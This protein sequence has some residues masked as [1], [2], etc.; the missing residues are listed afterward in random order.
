M[1]IRNK[2]ILA[3]TVLMAVIL[4]IGILSISSLK[5]V[6]NYSTVIDETVIPRL[7]CVENLNFEVARYRSYEYQHI[8]LS[9]AQS[10]SDVETKMNDLQSSIEKGIKEYQA[11]DNS[12]SISKIN[13][14]WQT[15]MTEHT[16][17]IEASRKLDTDLSMTV[18]K[19][20]SKTSYDSIAAELITLIAQNKEYSHTQSTN[21]NQAYTNIQN[22][23]LIVIILAMIA[24]VLIEIF[25][26]NSVKKPLNLMEVKLRELV[27]QGGDLTKKIEINSKDEIGRLA[28]EV[29]KF[30][31]N[32]RE[33]ILE[34]NT[35]T[36][37]VERTVNV[38]IDNMKE[39]GKSM[40]ESSATVQELSAGMEETA[41]SAEEINSSATEIDNAA[42]AMADR[43]QQG[44]MS[45]AEISSRAETLK[46]NAIKSQNLANDVYKSSKQNLENAI[47]K[48][49]A[50][51]QITVLSETILEISSQTNLLALNAAIEAARAGDAGKGFAVVA[52]EIRSLAENSKKTVTEIQRVTDEVVSSVNAL[53]TTSESFIDFFDS[54]VVN[55]YDEFVKVGVAYGKDGIYVDGLVGDFSATAEEL[56]ATI[57][58]IM[59][60][61]GEVS[62]T[63]NEGAM[64]TQ[65]MAEKISTIFTLVEDVNQQMNESLEET[66]QLKRAVSKFIV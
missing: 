55:D 17:L 3:F 54:T 7:E 50:I 61:M 21:G 13:A 59:K 29:N 46:E 30:I 24:G 60:A 52:D 15:Y 45:A 20:T 42:V 31:A 57:E 10:M 14:V 38:V 35:A 53:S 58:G 66:N 27:E 6:N 36:D 49:K 8:I 26:I 11:Y 56:T 37:G 1:T 2:L 32:I 63:V 64:G 12:N 62:S 51:S 28:A 40:E 65:D 23:V 44:A 47:E 33:I 48:S 19:G 41:A 4:G 39:V 16:K 5:K 25:L 43:A 18:I 9:D 22:I 34:V